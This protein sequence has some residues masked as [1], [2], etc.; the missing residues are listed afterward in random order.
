MAVN[1]E[2]RCNKMI[3]CYLVL[4]LFAFMNIIYREKCKCKLLR[5]VEK[6]LKN[7]Y[8]LFSCILHSIAKLITGCYLTNLAILAKL[9]ESMYIIQ[10][11]CH[12]PPKC[13][14]HIHAQWDQTELM[15]GFYG[16]RFADWLERNDM[17]CFFRTEI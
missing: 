9:S 6:H 8:C 1:K 13:A 12:C 4:I 5:N 14:N 7:M 3:I 2:K 17:D 15:N 16:P 10:F 11:S